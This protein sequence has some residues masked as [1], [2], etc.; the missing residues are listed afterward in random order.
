VHVDALAFAQIRAA[1][2]ASGDEQGLSV[3]V[4]QTCFAGAARVPCSLFWASLRA[5]AEPKPHSAA[6][7]IAEAFGEVH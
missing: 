2:P 6:V 7:T 3:P 4:A 1:E 5:V